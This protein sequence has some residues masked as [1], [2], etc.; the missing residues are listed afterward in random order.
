MTH[1][2]FNTE[3]LTRRAQL[4]MLYY[5]ASAHLVLQVLPLNEIIGTQ[6]STHQLV[7]DRCK[8]LLG[9]FLSFSL[10][11]IDIIGATCNRSG[12]FQIA[13]SS[14]YLQLQASY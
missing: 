2:T 6:V 1:S 9:K 10:Q 12:V 13:Q 3:Q 14:I 7:L 8:F 5:L 11:K 4:S